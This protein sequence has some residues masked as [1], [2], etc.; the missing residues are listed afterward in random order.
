[1]IR[2]G[3]S[4]DIW[5]LDLDRG[6]RRRLT[7]GSQS[8]FPVWSPD[9]AWIA[10]HQIV[11]GREEQIVKIPADGSGEA[12]LIA[13]TAAAPTTWSPDGQT[14]VATEFGTQTIWI[15]SIEGETSEL[16]AGPGRKGISSFSPDG[17]WLAYSS[18]E[19]G[20]E[21][22]H[23]RPFPGPGG[24]TVVSRGGKDPFW[25]PGGDQLFYYTPDTIPGVSSTL[26]AVDVELSNDS[27]QAGTPRRLFEG[28]YVG[29]DMSADGRFLM[30]NTYRRPPTTELRV[31]LNWTEELEQLVR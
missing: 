29:F 22:V 12:T 14:L 31:I 23:V 30:N 19:S 18:A 9:G 3:P 15:V 27:V 1:M 10:C 6:T 8:R 16:R 11:D 25:S 2:D 5:I 26:F 21:E 7:F 28:S 20:R 13:Q 24:V 4:L 17:R